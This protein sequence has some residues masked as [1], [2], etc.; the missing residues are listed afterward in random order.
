MRRRR[1]GRRDAAGQPGITH[2]Q[3]EIAERGFLGGQAQFALRRQRAGRQ[4]RGRAEAGQDAGRIGGLDGQVAAQGLASRQAGNQAGQFRAGFFARQAHDDVGGAAPVGAQPFDDG[5]HGDGQ[6]AQLGAAFSPE[7]PRA[8]AEDHARIQCGEAE[9]LVGDLAV[10]DG[11]ILDRQRVVA[12]IGGGGRFRPRGTV[13]RR[14]FYRCGRGRLGILEAPV[15][16]AVGQPGQGEHGAFQF[17]RLQP[18]FAGQQGQRG[19][20]QA[21]PPD[22]RQFS[23]GAGRI[24][25]RHAL[26]R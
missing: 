8:A 24:A 15:G 9:A 11:E 3:V 4:G 16:P 21:Q 5:V 22:P 6:L 2:R 12:R 26:G 17:Q 13:G 23:G 7:R 18:H 10:V 1:K 14:R 20:L 25:D 19:H